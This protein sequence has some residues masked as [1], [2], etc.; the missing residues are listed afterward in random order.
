MTERE[1][2]LLLGTAALAV[3]VGISWAGWY[4][5]P[6]P[7]ILAFGTTARSAAPADD[8]EYVEN[9]K[10]EYRAAMA[11]PSG[12]RIYWN[13]FNATEAER[14]RHDRLVAVAERELGLPER[15]RP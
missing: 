7:I 6:E 4:F 13:T 8:G 5:K 14:E 10:A 2:V 15:V 12:V 1:N 9:L 11:D 3:A